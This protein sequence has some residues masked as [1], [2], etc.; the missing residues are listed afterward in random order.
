MRQR[1]RSTVGVHHRN[2]PTLFAGVN[3]QKSDR[4]S[5]PTGC[6]YDTMGR[7]ALSTGEACK[8]EPEDQYR[9]PP[10]YFP[11]GERLEEFLSD[12]GRESGFEGGAMEPVAFVGI[13]HP[14]EGILS[15]KGTPDG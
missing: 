1:I 2:T 14:S 3:V 10:G 5:S 11:A 7:P 6:L 9:A 12:G 13:T 4:L 15:G 8:R